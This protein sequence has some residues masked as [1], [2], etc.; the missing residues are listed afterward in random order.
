[1]K[2]ATFAVD[3]ASRIGA[4]I[5]SGIV[6]LARVDAQLDV[7]MPG[8]LQGGEESMRRARDAAGSAAPHYALD[9]VVLR[10]PVLKPG[11]ILAIGMNYARH[12]QEAREM[13]MAVPDKQLWFNKQTTCINGPYD[14]I[15]LPRVSQ[16]LDYES[17]MALVIGRRCR[18]VAAENAAAVI[19][20]YTICNDVSVRDWQ[21]HTPTF[22]M[23]K[24]FDTHGPMGPWLVTPDEVGDPHK[25]DISCF[26]NG[27]KRQSSNTSDLIHNCFEQ[28]AYLSTAFTLEP[29]DVLVTGTPEGV[30]VA[31][32]PP[33]FLKVGDVV[34]CE[35]EKIGHIENVV[36]AEP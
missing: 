25:L 36:I 26:V 3:G 27:E 19:A 20:G 31:M 2:L 28:I 7:D 5:E 33:R 8:L 11:K 12:A 1:M 18:H 6:D 23:G 10:A 35:V 15:E 32:K 30:G 13:G 22:T 34:R 24:S 17:E 9:E 21:T 4:V 29:G 14:P 16:M